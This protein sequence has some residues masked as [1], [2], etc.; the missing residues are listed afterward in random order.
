M[1]KNPVI[2]AKF[3]LAAKYEDYARP[4]LA[5]CMPK[6]N[7]IRAMYVPGA[8]FFSRDGVQYSPAVV[9]HI[10]IRN[11]HPVDGE[12]YVHGWDL[13]RIN[14]AAGVNLDQPVEDTASVKF[15]IF[16]VLSP[17]DSAD[18]RRGYIESIVADGENL[19]AVEQKLLQ[20]TQYDAHFDACVRAGYEGQMLK[21][22]FAPYTAGRTPRLLKRKDWKYIDATVVE[23]FEGLGELGGMFGGATVE[24]AAG[25][26]FNVGCGKGLT[27]E[28]RIRIWRNPKTLLGKVVKVKY[29]FA[30]ADNKPLNATIVL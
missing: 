9:N 14:A 29:I 1:N 30:S 11:L 17:M 28:E 13:Q 7:G 21:L 26:R 5:I 15:H 4:P 12:F 23:V 2:A 6:L 25:V 22:P 27:H 19:V 24:T 8:G 16:D 3:M 18:R 10:K 20:Y